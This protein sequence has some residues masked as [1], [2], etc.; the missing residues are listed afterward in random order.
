[1][2]IGLGKNR[3]ESEQKKEDGN[4]WSEEG[5]EFKIVMRMGISQKM[6][7]NKT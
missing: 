7:L 3:A 4:C 1:M 5:M 6:T 2:A